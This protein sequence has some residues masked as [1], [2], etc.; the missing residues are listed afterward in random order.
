M[1]KSLVIVESPAKAKTISKFLGRNYKVK[2]SIGHIRD[3]PKSKLGIDIDKDFEPQYITIRGKG[4]ILKELRKEAKNAD[5]IYL[6][7]DPDREG[8]A[9]SWHLAHILGLNE[10]D[11][12][13]IEFNEITKGTIKNAIKKP[14]KINKDLVDA[15]Q[16]RRVLDRL[17]G[18]K[19]S[20]L[21]W[22]KVK[23][24]LSAGRVQSVAT[25]LICHREKEIEAFKPEEYW[26]ITARLRKGNEEFDASFYGE[27][28]KDKE[29]KVKLKNKEDVE[30]IRKYIA[31]EKFIIEEVKS[32][33]KKRNPY[34]PYTTSSLQQDANKRLG[35][36][37]KKTMMIAQQLYEGIDIKGEGTLGLI[38]Y[39]RTDSVR[40]SKEALE[41]TQKLINN[42]YGKEYASGGKQYVKGSKN[43]IQ[44][45]HEAIRP[46][47]VFRTPDSIK[48]S[49]SKDQYKLYKLI[50]ERFVASQM[51]PAIYETLSV[52]IVAGNKMFKAN[53]SK[54]KF[55]GF[56]K[57]YSSK[58]EENEINIPELKE[59]E[60]VKLVNFDGKQ[61]F[62]QP[63]SR[64]TEATLVK[65][66]EELGIGRPSTY[67][68]TIS[69]ILNRGYV[70]L[71][72]KYFRPTELGIIVTELLEEYFKDIVNEE[73]TADME[74][75]LDKIEVGELE[76]KS[77]I[78]DF[79]NKFKSTLET[80]EKEID[81]VEINDEVTDV[82]CEKCGRNMVIKHGRYGKFLA[83]PGYPEC[84]NAKP[85]V[86]EIGV[87]CP[88]CGGEIIERKSKRGRKFF[89]CA[90][91]PECKFV[92]W[93]E[94]INEK[95]PKCGS[96]LV[97]KTYKTKR[98][99]IICSNK[100]CDFKRIDKS[101][102]NR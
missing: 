69:T 87:K 89:G 58:S 96:I 35:F 22:R 13:R 42:E 16:A 90:N 85:L 76:W 32:G 55:D 68:P 61:H 1:A 25:K 28:I 33:T 41:N 50:W 4:D 37:T 99:A 31:K 52:K 80:A 44:D 77:L 73:F 18:Y 54:M 2:A 20:P 3:L 17:V 24:G 94:P 19:I 81:K 8:E 72:N 78:R 93:N 43:S 15:Q 38:T 56:M 79:Y 70:V 7:T 5:R 102:N 60:I 65:T 82:K 95:C 101:E 83:C 49:L 53:G 100:G 10:E 98:N 48:D 30:K 21:L 75:K 71:E 12:I 62:T 36:S 45:A 66:L 47:S 29:N 34:P 64:Y 97:K 59:G 40:I 26:T 74:D 88:E 9:I 57:V 86:K 51:N 63:P 92:T 46:T 11:N 14:R 39:I 23:K 84:K 67:A 27:I 6:A 91:Y